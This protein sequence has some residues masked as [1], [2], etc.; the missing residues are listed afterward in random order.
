M[1]IAIKII[2]SAIPTLLRSVIAISSSP[3]VLISFSACLL[4]AG[5]RQYTIGH[6]TQMSDQTLT[7]QQKFLQELRTGCH[8]YNEHYDTSYGY[9][10]S[11]AAGIAFLVLFGL[12]MVVHTVQAA[13]KRTWWTLLFSIGCL[14]MSLL[15]IPEQ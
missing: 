14:S 4:L 7:P 12:S 11:V 10:P 5:D 8:A 2:T 1:P 9:V 6:S 3:S 15:R 13:W